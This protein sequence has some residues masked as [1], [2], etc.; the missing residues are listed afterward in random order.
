MS[1]ASGLGWSTLEVEDSG[2]NARSVINDITDLDFAT[3]EKYPTHF[4]DDRLRERRD[5]Y[6]N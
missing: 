2:G 1:K 4:I 6:L 3:L 5:G